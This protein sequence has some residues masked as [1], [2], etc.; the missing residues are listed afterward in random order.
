MAAVADAPPDAA[1]RTRRR[2]AAVYAAADACTPE[3]GSYILKK[4]VVGVSTWQ[5]LAGIAQMRMEMRQRQT[6]VLNMA[7]LTEECCGFPGWTSWA[8]YKLRKQTWASGGF[9]CQ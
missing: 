1:K 6:R 3:S 2:R 4:V 5:A 8:V 9:P 7:A